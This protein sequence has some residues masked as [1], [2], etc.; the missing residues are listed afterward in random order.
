MMA[1]VNSTVAI[2]VAL[3][4]IAFG[5]LNCFFGYRIFKFMLG[6]Y[7][8]FL[9]AVVGFTVASSATDGQ[10]LW[11]VLGALIG[12]AVGAA[13]MVL[14]YFVGVFAVGGLAGA[15][16]AD[17]IGAAFGFDVPLLVA[18]VVAV[19]A[20]VAALFFQ[21]YALIVATALSGA[22][23]AVASLFSLISGQ[24]LALR[25][26]FR[27]SGERAGVPLFVV[28]ILWLVLSVAGAIVQLRTT[29]EE[30]L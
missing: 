27:L 19:V 12:G 24:G 6:I 18:I 16:L 30:P 28:L 25:E 11:L 26:V 5:L 20:G 9:G 4:S 22:W 15:L 8:F 21:R 13:L 29:A 3:V 2:L 10:V 23:V 7:G 1:D 17:T 14:L